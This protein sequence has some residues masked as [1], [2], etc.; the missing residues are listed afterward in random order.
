MIVVM[1]YGLNPPVYI[2]TGGGYG[3]IESVTKKEIYISVLPS[4]P[5]TPRKVPSGHGTKSSI[6]YLHVP[7]V[8]PKVTVRLSG[9]PLIQ[10]SLRAPGP[11]GHPVRQLVPFFRCKKA[12]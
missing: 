1:S 5:S 10:D 12:N 11:R 8:R 6:L 7:T 2:N 4:L 9:Y 3:Y